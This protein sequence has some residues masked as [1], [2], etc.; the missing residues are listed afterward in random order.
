MKSIKMILLLLLAAALLAGCGHKTDPGSRPEPTPTPLIV[1]E[2]P[3]PTPTPTPAPTATPAPTPA[4]T[5]AATPAPTPMPAVT[6]TPTSPP[7]VT[8]TP[9]PTPAA[10]SS[11]AQASNLPVV[12][13]NPTNQTVAPGGSCTFSANY[14]NAIYATWHFVSPDGQTDL[15]YGQIGTKFPNL[16]VE[17]GMY[18]TMTLSNVPEAINSWRVYCCYRN[19]YG[20]VNTDRATIQ[21]TPAAAAQSS[22]GRQTTT[23]TTTV[24]YNGLYVEED[25]DGWTMEISSD[26]GT[27]YVTVTWF[28]NSDEIIIWEFSGKFNGDRVMYYDN[29]VKT[30][31]TYDEQGEEYQDVDSYV[32]DGILD[33]WPSKS[34]IYWTDDDD[35]Y[36]IDE[37]FFAAA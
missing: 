9:T 26:S 28:V 4:P 22:A 19:D 17:N 29:G 6:T 34:G 20:S 13:L 1:E 18:S 21:V 23:T 2:T 27:Y 11:S 37:L 7:A 36:D 3:P 24:N 10:A 33:Y 15:D 35:V 12:T 8:P 32:H 16:V 14:Q 25:D 31:L 30:I 5:P